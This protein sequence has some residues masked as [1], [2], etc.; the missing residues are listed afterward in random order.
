MDLI[1]VFSVGG[2]LVMPPAVCNFLPPRSLTGDVFV[3]VLLTLPF[4]A[5]LASPSVTFFSSR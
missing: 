4:S 1:A 3:S 2:W 5:R